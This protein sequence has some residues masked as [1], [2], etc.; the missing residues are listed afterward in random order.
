MKT[1]PRKFFQLIT[2]QYKST[3]NLQDLEVIACLVK[4][5]QTFVILYLN[6]DNELLI[7]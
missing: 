7:I 6:I 4:N 5:D 3:A 1:N 2:K